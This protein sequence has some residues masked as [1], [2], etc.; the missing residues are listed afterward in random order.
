MTQSLWNLARGQ[1]GIIEGFDEQLPE[2]YRNRLIEL[3]FHPGEQVTCLQAPALGAP[4]V[5]RV[6]NSTFSLDDDVAR[7]LLLRPAD[8]GAA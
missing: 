8:T 3:G 4:R 7:F 5:Y 2:R 6:S 1:A